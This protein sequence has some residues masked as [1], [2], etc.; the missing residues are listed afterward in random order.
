MNPSH[1]IS[2][3]VNGLRSILRKGFAEFLQTS[4]ADVVCLQ[5]IKTRPEQI[6]DLAWSQGWEIFWNPAQKPGYSGTATLSR[7]PVL[8]HHLGLGDPA[9]DSEGRVVTTEFPAFYLVNVYV[10]NAQ[11]E[12]TRLKYRAEGWSP[13]FAHYLRN[14]EKTKPVIVCGD[15][16]VAHQE[17]DL[18][19]PRENVGNAGFT[20][21]ERTCFQALLDQG[22]LDTFR[23]FCQDGGHYTWWS[24]QNQAR[25]RNIGWRIDYFLTS[26]KLRPHLQAARIHPEVPGSDHCPISLKLSWS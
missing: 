9:H 18:A 4:H 7:T 24:Y 19:R 21:E 15:L 14:L 25:P 1:L 12:L 5:E 8:S 17:I 20:H 22:L 6:E 2:W 26:A 13:A 11:R 23:E 10:P 16:N 3:N